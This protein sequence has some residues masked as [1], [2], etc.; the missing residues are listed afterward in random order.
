MDTRPDGTVGSFGDSLMN[1]ASPFR[2]GG[3]EASAQHALEY[4]GRESVNGMH[5]PNAFIDD[6]VMWYVNT[7]QQARCADDPA[8]LCPWTR[9][10]VEFDIDRRLYRQTEVHEMGHCH[11]LRHDFGGSADSNNYPADYYR[12]TQQYPLP[13][14][15]AFDTDGTPGFSLSEQQTYET[16]Y[17]GA[18]HQRELAGIDAWMSSSVMDY[19][20]AWYERIT[21]SASHDWMAIGLG[22]GGLVDIYHNTTHL[23]LA[24][25]NPSTVAR[26]YVTYYQGGGLCTTDADCAYSMTGERATDLTAANM[27]AHLT[28]HCVANPNLPR[29]TSARTSTTIRR[30]S[31][32]R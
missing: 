11:G 28:Q 26:E 22:Y 19:T 15:H 30:P 16:A 25:V 4:T 7:S 13:N 21:G 6:S 27:A 18:R 29:S 3:L 31:C 5:M 2:S 20:G 1:M 12:I 14:P 23:P 8:R 9:A 17:S 32:R 10:H 24:Q